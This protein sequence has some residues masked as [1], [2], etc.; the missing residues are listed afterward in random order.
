MEYELIKPIV[1]VGNSAGVILPKEWLNGR[2]QIKLVQKPLNIKQEIFSLL[3][4]YLKDILGIYL[5]GSYARGEED[6]SSDIDVLVITEKENKRILNGKYEII[7]ISKYDLEKTLKKNILPLLPMLKEAKSILNDKLIE[8]YIETRITRKNLKFH[9][10]LSKSAMKMEKTAIELAEM[11]NENISDNIMYSLVLRLRQTYIVDCLIKNKKQN[12]KDFLKLVRMITGSEKSY[13]AYI[14][15]K[16]NEKRQEIIS[17]L[18]AKKIY[19]YLKKKIIKQ[20]KWVKTK[21]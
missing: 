12:N 18:E 8:N 10:E 9:I 6:N 21:R 1:K 15:S 3:E 16:N 17:L 13:E 5:V 4:P 19:S 2:A 7:L 14:R 20:E 11:Q